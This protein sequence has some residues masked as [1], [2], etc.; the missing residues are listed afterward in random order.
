MVNFRKVGLTVLW[1]QFVFFIAYDCYEGLSPIPKAELRQPD[2]I[3]PRDGRD[4]ICGKDINFIQ[5]VITQ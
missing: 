3:S 4:L 5:L 1:F 2:F